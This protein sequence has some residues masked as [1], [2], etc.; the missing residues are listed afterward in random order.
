MTTPKRN[1][2]Q[3]KNLQEAETFAKSLASSEGYCVS[4]RTSQLDPAKGTRHIVL[5]CVQGGHYRVTWKEKST[6][7]PKKRDSIKVGCKY[8]IRI[9]EKDDQW[10]VRV[11]KN[12]HNHEPRAPAPKRIKKSSE[13]AVVTH[14]GLINQ[15]SPEDVVRHLVAEV[16]RLERSGYGL[17]DTSEHHITSQIEQAILHAELQAI[18]DKMPQ[19][20]YHQDHQQQSEL[21]T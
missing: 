11:P 21:G 18:H 4:R 12:M 10:N 6:T 16:A 17:I 2:A 14:P 9:S 1:L 15:E 13:E 3:F 7:Y 19:Q 5:G 8:S 20:V